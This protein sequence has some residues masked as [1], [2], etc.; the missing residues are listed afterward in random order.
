MVDA[1]RAMV[2][3]AALAEPLYSL[4]S[5]TGRST[6]APKVGVRVLKI[7]AWPSNS[8]AFG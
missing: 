5:L 2:K 4:K 8:L 1:F 6:C 7:S 3:V